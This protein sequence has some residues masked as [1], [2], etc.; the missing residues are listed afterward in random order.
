MNRPRRP[1]PA[2]T[3]TFY[4]E[5]WRRLRRPDADPAALG[6]LASRIA[7]AFLDNHYYMDWFDD[8]ALDVL[9]DMGTFFDDDARRRAAAGALF[10]TIIERL[11]DDFEH[12]Q[13]EAYNR[14][15]SRILTFCRN[16]PGGEPLDRALDGFGL[17]D[18]DDLYRRAEHIRRDAQR[19]FRETGPV[20]KVFVL[21]RVTIGADVAITSV[22]VQRLADRFPGARIVLVGG[23]NLGEL[24]GSRPGLRLRVVDYPRRGALLNRFAGWQAVLEALREELADTPTER[25]VLVDP[26]SRL[27]QLGV[28]PVAPAETCF[29]L[30]SRIDE[31]DAAALAMSELANRWADTTFGPTGYRHPALWL[32]E[33]LTGA[34]GAFAAGLRRAGCRR[35]IG[36]ALG[37]GEN[38]RKRIGG[39]FEERLLGALLEEPR[40]V[41]LLDKGAGAEEARRIGALVEAVRRR[42]HAVCDA[43]FDSLGG[44]HPAEGLVAVETGIGQIAALIGR[45][46]EFIGYDSA[47]QHIAAALGVTCYTVF[48]GTNSSRFVRRWRARG[49]GSA[50]IIHVDTLSH[51][52]AVDTEE[53]V[54][55][56]LDRRSQWHPP[57]DPAARQAAGDAPGSEGP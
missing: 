20:E 16:V 49:P 40:T 28:L 33:A 5:E 46:D 18:G 11:C 34:A 9:C 2:R 13:A 39:D 52:Q 14:V 42:G 31:D 48:A 35:L 29:F 50:H 7:L 55:R 15:I 3:P 19:P 1:S 45:C 53:V 25:T 4:Q 32:P 27:T 22:L 47:C 6:R 37:V 24:F 43:A 23:A 21:S 36:V 26:D 12:L 44:V 41:V 54:A 51:P 56:I 30:N 57:E 38:E 8:G 10:G 17:H